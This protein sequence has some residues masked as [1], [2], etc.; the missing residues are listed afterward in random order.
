MTTLALLDA[1]SLAAALVGMIS[2]VVWPLFRTRQ[3][4]LLVQLAHLGGCAL[5]YGI[6]G[7]ATATMVISLSAAQVVSSLMWGAD[8]RRKWVGYGMIPATVCASMLTWSGSPSLLAATGT[9]L[10]AIGRVQVDAGALRVLVLAGMPFWLAH[11]IMIGSPLVV[12]DLLS[13]AMGMMAILRVKGES[14]RPQL[15]PSFRLHRKPA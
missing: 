12:A 13:I 1:V 9:L 3:H 15:R 4:M 11:D 14:D 7:A 10:I 6:E 8:P 5:H 2:L